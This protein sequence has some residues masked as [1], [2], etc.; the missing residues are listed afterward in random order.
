[1]KKINKYLKD[2]KESNLGLKIASYSALAG[3]FLNYAPEMAAQCP[4]TAGPAGDLNI[5]IDGDGLADVDITWS[6]NFGTFPNY[7]TR[8]GGSFSITTGTFPVYYQYATATVPAVTSTFLGCNLAYTSGGSVANFPSVSVALTTTAIAIANYEVNGVNTLYFQYS[9]FGYYQAFAIATAGPGNLII[10]LTS[11]GASACTLACAGGS[12]AFLGSNFGT[13]SFQFLYSAYSVQ[14][15]YN[16]APSMDVVAQTCYTAP[17]CTVDYYNIAVPGVQVCATATIAA[18]AIIPSQTSTTF[19]PYMNSA[20]TSTST[21]IPNTNP[22]QYL[23]V[24]FIGGDGDTYN[25]WVNIS[26]D[27]NTSEVTCLGSGYNMCSIEAAN[28]KAGTADACPPGS[29]IAVG[30]P[31]FT[32]DICICSPDAG[33]L[34]A[35]SPGAM[36]GSKENERN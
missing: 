8:S 12:G 2:S 35:A 34:P 28:T 1:M 33:A 22:T 10:G 14:I 27:P 18:G 19:G 15:I 6:A 13:F 7:T 11:S 3:A 32:G 24:K 30:T 9:N 17:S 29:N 31:T 21:F 26:I 36:I 20:S 16:T 4:G 5:D 23:A 25:G